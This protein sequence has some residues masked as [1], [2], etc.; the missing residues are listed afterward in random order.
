MRAIIVLCVLTMANA[1]GMHPKKPSPFKESAEEA[2]IWNNL[3][4]GDGGRTAFFSQVYQQHL[5]VFKATPDS[6]STVDAWTSE[7]Q[8]PNDFM[9]KYWDSLQ[10]TKAAASLRDNKGKEV[11][12]PEGSWQDF[13]HEFYDNGMSVVVRRENMEMVDEPLETAIKSTLRAT[14]VTTHAYL[15]A[16]EAHALVPHVD[17]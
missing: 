15:S 12:L 14:G 10:K 1:R 2:H 4:S 8:R 16:G 3:L 7:L 9:T 6:L 17:P 11:D 13:Q 5:H